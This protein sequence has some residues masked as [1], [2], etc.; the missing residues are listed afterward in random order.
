MLHI[1][2]IQKGDGTLNDFGSKLKTL[3]VNSGLTIE[4]LATRLNKKYNTKLSKSSISRWE[5]GDHD[6]KLETVRILCDFF[7]ISAQYFIK[8][9]NSDSNIIHED[10]TQYDTHLRT[11]AAHID[12]DVTEKELEDIMD[13]IEYVKNKRK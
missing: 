9:S 10:K 6:P 11:I 12:D 8:D 5:N 1:T 4:E 13:Y 2:Y 3:R 7:E